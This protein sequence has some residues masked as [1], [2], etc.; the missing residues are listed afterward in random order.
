M[1]PLPQSP[2]DE[3]LEAVL[4]ADP[5]LDAPVPEGPAGSAVWAV[6]A[7]TLREALRP[8]PGGLHD[9]QRQ[10]IL[11]A[12]MALSEPARPVAPALAAAPARRR[13]PVLWMP[14]AT[15]ACFALLLVVCARWI[16]VGGG[17]HPPSRAV[18]VAKPA[19]VP[20]RLLPRGVVASMF[21]A[22]TRLPDPPSLALEDGF[23]SAYRGH[24]AMLVPNPASAG[25]ERVRSAMR[26][27]GQ[28]PAAG[29]VAIEEMINYFPYGAATPA[30]GQPVSLAAEYGPCP[31][32]P[33][34]R[35]VRVSLKA[36]GPPHHVGPVAR[37]VRLVMDFNP[38]RIS[39][40]RLIGYKGGG[41]SP[42]LVEVQGVD[43][44]RGQSATVLYEVIPVSAAGSWQGSGWQE[45]V[46][47]PLDPSSHL[48]AARVVYRRPGRPEPADCP[49]V[50]PDSDPWMGDVSSDFRFAAAVAAC[51]MILDHS[52]GIGN[53]RFDDV[54][55]LA[56]TSLDHDPDGRR[57]EFVALVKYAAWMAREK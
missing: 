52:P 3:A 51:G 41:S 55:E 37:D 23:Q 1:N 27:D 45:T 30:P 12:A 21:P 53:Y 32:E 31:W 49:V 2:R 8:G 4:A 7:N 43:L 54:L 36:W 57:A 22:S 46:A 25:F 18:A 47:G 29:S 50:V 40:F 11:D 9:R 39:A 14:V 15:A 34:H 28:L 16:P 56:S 42:R 44:M 26:H 38:T 24:V 5:R 6:L 35:L 10:R 20:G 19:F 13:E 33:T 48:L 17:W